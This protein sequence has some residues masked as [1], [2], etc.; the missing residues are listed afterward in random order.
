MAALCAALCSSRRVDAGRRECTRRCHARRAS[1]PP[2]SHLAPLLALPRPH[3][4]V[5]R[6]LDPHK[7]ARLRPVA[8]LGAHVG[9][10]LACAR[11][12]SA[13]R[14]KGGEASERSGQK[15]REAIEWRGGGGRRAP[16]SSAEPR[17]EHR[18]A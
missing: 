12:R 14:A 11:G 16:R 1:P 7:L 10:R 9:T 18:G 4:R 3:D 13:G 15:G 5:L 6:A 8:L 17:A 2:L